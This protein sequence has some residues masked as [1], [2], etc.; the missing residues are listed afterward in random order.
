MKKGIKPRSTEEAR[1]SA[2]RSECK[3]DPKVA[4]AEAFGKHCVYTGLFPGFPV[5]ESITNG[6]AHAIGNVAKALFALIFDVKSMKFKIDKRRWELGRHRR[7]GKIPFWQ[8][9]PAKI[10]FVKDHM[11]T[12][13]VPKGWPEVVSSV[14]SVTTLKLDRCLALAGDMGRYFLE[15][16]CLPPIIEAPMQAYLKALQ[17]CQ[18]KIPEK[19]VRD[20]HERL[21]EAAAHL[22][23]LLPAYWNSI[24]KHYILHIDR[25]L[26]L[27]GCFWSSNE[28]VHERLIGKVKAMAKHGNKNRA[29]TLAINFGIFQQTEDWL[30]EEELDTILA[31]K[32][33]SFVLLSI[34]SRQKH[35]L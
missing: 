5:L 30:L 9:P 15:M 26:T 35:F 6:P 24:T 33:P 16:F 27:W 34:C 10:E 11:R 18:Q 13:K 7:H 17:D 29:K 23:A 32:V 31:S 4:K 12:L 2:A 21:V 14:E 28:L 19:S 20:I 1:A 8:A 25:I 22:E 3:K